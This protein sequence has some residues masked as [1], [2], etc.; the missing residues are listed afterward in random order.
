M[1]VRLFN[2]AGKTSASTTDV[3]ESEVLI[4]RA[5][6]RHSILR[7]RVFRVNRVFYGGHLITS[8]HNETRQDGHFDG[9]PRRVM[10][11]RTVKHRSKDNG[12][13][14]NH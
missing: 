10:T 4:R 9:V 5:F 13:G 3:N 11:T 12:P 1:V 7:R 6:L 2:T 14:R 8:T